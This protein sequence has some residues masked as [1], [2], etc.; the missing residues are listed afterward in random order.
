M[1]AVTSA[2]ITVTDHSLTFYKQVYLNF[3]NK[4]PEYKIV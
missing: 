2:V 1:T 4:D 3:T